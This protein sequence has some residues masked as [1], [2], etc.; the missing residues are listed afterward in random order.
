MLGLFKSKK[1]LPRPKEGELT[2]AQTL[3]AIGD[4]GLSAPIMTKSLAASMATYRMIRNDPTVAIARE[5]AIAPILCGNWTIESNKGVPLERKEF[6]ESQL[7][8]IRGMIMEASLGFGHCD[9]G[10]CGFEKVFEMVDGKI[11][12]RKLKPLLHDITSIL[13]L[14][15]TGAFA[16][17]YQETSQG[18]VEIPLE[19]SFLTSFRVEGTDWYGNGL[20]ERVRNC[21]NWWVDANEGA[22]KYDLKVAGSHLVVEYPKGVSKLDNVEVSNAVIAKRVLESLENCGSVTVPRDVSDIPGEEPVKK[23]VFNMLEDKGGRQ[24]TFVERL[25]YLDTL[26]VRAMVLPERALLE[27]HF[28]TKAEAQEHYDLALTYMQLL[29]RHITT[30]VNWHIVDQLL[31][32]NFGEDTRGTIRLTAAPLSD[33]VAS[34]MRELYRTI[35]QSTEGFLLEYGKLDIETF[36]RRLEIPSLPEDERKELEAIKGV[37]P[38]EGVEPKEENKGVETEEE[39]DV[40]QTPEITQEDQAASELLGRVGGITGMLDMFSKYH[41]K[42]I[43]AETLVQLIMLF[44]R[45]EEEQARAI[46]N[47][48]PEQG[49]APVEEDWEDEDEEDWEDEDE[50]DLEDEEEK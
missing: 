9:F 37:E 39:S 36:R 1:E 11:G 25:K 19:K 24:P 8:G 5:L 14:K 48:L 41:K 35:I 32:L 27:G 2:A 21:Y 3:R 26:K 4:V 47:T 17:F 46:V 13:V 12:L 22:R 33:E 40:E 30:M 6:I 38:E 42:E 44:F 31:A 18:K 15:E 43:T 7:V 20:L 50:E 34:Y 16:G 10:W 23:W 29:D 28:G 45:V 49:E